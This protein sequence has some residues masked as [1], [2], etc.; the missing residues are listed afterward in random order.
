MLDPARERS[1][2]Q[3]AVQG[4]TVNAGIGPRS[5]IGKPLERVGHGMYILRET[6]FPPAS[7]KGKTV[8]R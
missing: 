7:L 2:I 3:P 1:T 8:L 5:R 4:M 6:G